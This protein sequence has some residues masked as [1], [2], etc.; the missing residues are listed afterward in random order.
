MLKVGEVCASLRSCFSVL[1]FDDGGVDENVGLK[2]SLSLLHFLLCYTN[3]VKLIVV[4][5]LGVQYVRAA[6]ALYTNIW[7]QKH[8]GR[9]LRYMIDPTFGVSSLQNLA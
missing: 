3:I 2:Y 9:S 6:V 1:T 7:K 4:Y 8:R 5:K